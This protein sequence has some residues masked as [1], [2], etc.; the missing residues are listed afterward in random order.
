MEKKTFLYEGK[1]KTIYQSAKEDE[2]TIYYK[3]DATALNGKMKSTIDNKGI[4]NNEITVAIF[5]YLKEKGIPTHYLKQ[6]NDRE[7]LCRKV[8]ILPLEVI[9]RNVVA[10]SMA[11][12]LG[13][14]EGLVLDEPVMELCYKEDAL[15]DP[16]INDDHAIV[17]KAATREDLAIIYTLTKAINKALIELFN[18]MG[19]TLVDFK[20]EFGKDSEGNILLA[21]EIS[22]DTCRLW[23]TESGEKLDKDRFR[24]NL[25]GVEGAYKEMTRRIKEKKG[26]IVCTQADSLMK[27]VEFLVF[28]AM[29][30]VGP[31]LIMVYIV[32]NI[33]DKRAVVSSPIMEMNFI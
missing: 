2:V 24:R 28:M 13:L 29:R 3:D 9:L 18:S 31:L 8:T 20:I 12:R 30:I 11:K 23:D 26:F 33:E 1:A 17:L 14:E 10:D 15:D 6:L 27:N 25:G 19:I 5:E 16:L 4:Y 22:P 32:Y 21:D 7:Q